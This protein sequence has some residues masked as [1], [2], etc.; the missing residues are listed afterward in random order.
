MTL[1]SLFSFFI[2]N[3][4][5]SP[6]P[7]PMH[8]LVFR[9]PPSFPLH[10]PP[11]SPPSHP[12]PRGMLVCRS[13]CSSSVFFSAAKATAQRGCSYPS[14]LH[15]YRR[16]YSSIVSS[17]SEGEE[18]GENDDVENRREEEVFE[19]DAEAEAEIASEIARMIDDDPSVKKKM[20]LLR[21]EANEVA[22]DTIEKLKTA[23]QKEL[24]ETFAK[25]TD[26]VVSA[27]TDAESAARDE[28]RIQ[29]DRVVRAEETMR[30]VEEETKRMKEDIES[31]STAEKEEDRIESVKAS[32]IAATGGVFVSTPLAMS[33]F[34]ATFNQFAD[35]G[36]VAL[37]C[38]LFG[39]VYRYAVR[40][41]VDDLQLKGGVVASFALTRGVVEAE[42][43]I[44]SATSAASGVNYFEIFTQALAIVGESVVVFLFAGLCIEAAMQREIVQRKKGTE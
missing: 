32:A 15:R 21:R 24:R 43:F 27:Q 31:S 1:S 37:S 23:N 8:L 41:N 2:F 36:A 34:E 14:S 42:M 11:R 13:S 7:T 18:E 33:Q 20:E 25:T 29:E 22:S 39:I 19:N 4:T 40:E 38:F 35:V 12:S 3:Y 28:L 9:H 6:T 44:F 16:R 30:R 5:D 26:R 17:S 10:P